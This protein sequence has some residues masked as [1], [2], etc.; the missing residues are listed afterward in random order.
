[1]FPNKERKSSFNMKTSTKSSPH[2]KSLVIN[3]ITETCPF[4]LISQAVELSGVPEK[5]IRKLPLRKFGNAHYVSP[6][7]L[8]KFILT[9]EKPEVIK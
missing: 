4:V 2:A 1:M 6:L 3:T 5:E 8:N 7:V 9:G